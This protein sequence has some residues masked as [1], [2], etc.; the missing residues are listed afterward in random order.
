V[1]YQLQAV[2]KVLDPR[3]KHAAFNKH[4]HH[5]IS[6]GKEGWTFFENKPEPTENG[7]WFP[8]DEYTGMFDAE[9]F[10]NLAPYDGPWE[11]SLVERE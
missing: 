1:Y 8:E 10:F 5:F 9:P 11:E 6:G 4:E 3:W 2:F 7:L